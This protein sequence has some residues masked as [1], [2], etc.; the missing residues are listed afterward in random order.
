MYCF[1]VAADAARDFADGKSALAGHRLQDAP[2][3]AHER[4]PEQVGR[5]ER[6]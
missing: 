6:R 5:G 3:A 1:D 4:L 2:A